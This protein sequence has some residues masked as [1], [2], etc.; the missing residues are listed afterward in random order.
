GPGPA[1]RSSSASS[2]RGAA[3]TR[4]VAHPRRLRVRGL[5]RRPSSRQAQRATRGAGSARVALDVSIA[6][7]PT[8][9]FSE[10]GRLTE[11][12]EYYDFGTRVAPS[13]PPADQV[14][15]LTGL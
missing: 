5:H 4:A 12:V 3:G 11:T 14:T 9:S 15:D 13:I 10:T 8:G 7:A 1:S 2:Q 6:G